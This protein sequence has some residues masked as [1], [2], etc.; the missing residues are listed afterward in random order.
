MFQKRTKLIKY[1]FFTGLHKFCWFTVNPIFWNN[2][3]FFKLSQ[4]KIESVDILSWNT[5]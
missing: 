3:S 5:S 2:N 1:F 4:D